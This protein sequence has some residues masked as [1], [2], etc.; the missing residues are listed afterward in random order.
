M[1]DGFSRKTWGLGAGA[2]LG[3]FMP[4]L[5]FLYFDAFNIGIGAYPM[6]Q[7]FV[8]FHDNLFYPVG[9]G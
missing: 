2:L 9:H 7:Y 6:K 4:Y 1:F 8:K 5:L 3:F